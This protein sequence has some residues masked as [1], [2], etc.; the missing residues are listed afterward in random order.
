MMSK[1]ILAER[2]ELI[3]RI[4]D[5]GMASVYRAH[6]Q[7]LDRYVAVKIL[8]PQFAN[9]EEF[10]VRFKK[11]AQ[12]AAKLS[13]TNIVNIYDV[14]EWDKQYFIVMEYVEGETLKNKIQREG[15]LSIADVLD[16]SGQIVEALEHAHTHN[17]IHCDIKPH[18]I[19]IKP[20]GQVKVADFGIARAASSATMTYSGNVVGSVHYI[21]P[22]QA[23][24]NAITPKSDIYSLG[25]VIYEMLT[26]EVPFKGENVVSIALK[27]LQEIPVPIH[28]LRPDVPP[29]VEAIVLKAMEKDPQKRFSSTQMI[30][31]IHKAQKMLFPDGEERND[32][33]ATRVIPRNQITEAMN[34][35][36]NITS[37]K[38]I[39]SIMKSKKFIMLLVFILLLGFFTGAFLSFG[40][41]WSNTEV[42]VP[43]VVGQSVEQA[44]TIITSKN[45]RVQVTEVYNSDIA[46]GYV[47]SQT[48][49]A[50]TKVK[51]ERQ[52]TLYVSKGAETTSVP[53]VTGFTKEDAERQLQKA[54]LKI[55]NIVAVASDKPAGVV[56]SQDP[57][58]GMQI[59]KGNA[60]NLTISK[61]EEVKTVSVPDVTGNTLNTAKIILEKA[62]F[63]IGSIS[64]QESDKAPG[65]V[66]GQSPRSGEKLKE[67]SVVN[68]IIAKSKSKK[69]AVE[70]TNNNTS[71][72]N[73]K[74]GNTQEKKT[75]D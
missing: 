28:E 70:K 55:G 54:G 23:Q 8:H 68:L 24:G 25:V 63:T 71:S 27:H 58:P 6:D 34:T 20:N 35:D 67:K 7:L 62:G 50:G 17:L 74:K 49:N 41:F 22:E 9:D 60:V 47:V 59:E 18:N 46:K 10:I 21:S 12:G 29:I 72:N 31:E 2:Y 51:E 11:E 3:E 75:K 32:P 4:G 40:K 61:G 1:Q 69:E 42:V 13:H 44:K 16:I 45:L 66:L 56:L 26:G 36:K 30:L 65:T 33:Y 43:N 64:E 73:V 5:G 53:D 19:L 57:I 48:P 14:G 38:P 37:K 39:H 15:K 52:I